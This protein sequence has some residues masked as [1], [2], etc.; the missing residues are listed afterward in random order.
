MQ[1][2]ATRADEHDP[3]RHP[4]KMDARLQE[5]I[6]HL[7]ADI[8]KVDEPQFKAMFEPAAEVLGGLVTAFRHYEQKSE[9]AWQP[10]AARAERWRLCCSGYPPFRAFR[11]KRDPVFGMHRGTL[12]RACFVGMGNDSVQPNS[13]E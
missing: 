12:S 4:R 6:D 13:A 8:D 9:G 7:R 2:R 5:T 3:I 11:C 1:Q 10:R